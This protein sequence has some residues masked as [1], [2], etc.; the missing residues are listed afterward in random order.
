VHAALAIAG[1]DLRQRFRDRSAIVL[2]FIAPVGIA[3]LMSTALSGANEFH[4]SL[5]VVNDDGGPIAGALLDVLE[6]PGLSDI[7]TV[8]SIPTADDARRQVDDGDVAVGLVV[9]AGFSDAAVALDPASTASVQLLANADDALAA[10]VAAAIADGFLAQVNASRL[11]VRT[12]I[13]AGAPVD[14]LGELAAAAAEDRLPIE[15][16]QRSAGSEPLDPISYYAPS[17]G[18]FFV[19]FAVGFA[20][21]SFF[22]ERA[23]G[24]LERMAV[25]PVARRSILAGKA[26]SV[27][28][29][30]VASMTALALVTGILFGADWGHPLAAAVLIVAVGLAVVALTALVIAVSRTDRQADA[31]SSV[32]V[33]TLAILG[34]SFIQASELPPLMRTFALATPNGWAL[35]GFVDLGTT[36][37]GAG[38]DL[39]LVAGPTL[40]ILAFTAVAGALATVASRRVA[41]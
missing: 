22:T 31:V 38:H 34:G 8:E 11:S 17:M 1:K 19:L 7:V 28:G 18:M 40:G 41:S 33:F 12:A 23:Q 5:G 27:L 16:S 35:R 3:A 10:E 25:A 6:S 36:T 26:L 37:G 2:G 20:S 15:I 30:A 14:R 21:R 9:P 24:T 29:Y 32:V 4:F 39:R 13:S